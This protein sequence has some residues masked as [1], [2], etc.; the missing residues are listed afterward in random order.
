MEKKLEYL[1]WRKDDDIGWYISK[2]SFNIKDFDADDVW[3]FMHIFTEGSEILRVGASMYEL[4]WRT[5]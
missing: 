3:Y 4:N 1:L 5:V 2:S